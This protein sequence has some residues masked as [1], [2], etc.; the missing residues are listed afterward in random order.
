MRQLRSVGRE[1]WDSSQIVGR[2]CNSADD[3]D[4]PRTARSTQELCDDARL[5]A[6]AEDLL[7]AAKE[8]AIVIAKTATWGVDPMKG[9]CLRRL[10]AA[11][12]RAEGK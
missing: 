5:F 1:I 3:V 8:A 11:I 12:K 7:L 4:D 10:L 9:T 2:A 6:A